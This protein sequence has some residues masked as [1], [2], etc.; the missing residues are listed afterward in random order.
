MACS[1][2][3]VEPAPGATFCSQ[4]GTR[5]DFKCPQCSSVVQKDDRFC[6]QCGHHLQSG[7]IESSKGLICRLA[8]MMFWNCMRLV[9]M[10]EAMI[11]S[12]LFSNSLMAQNPSI[13]GSGSVFEIK[14]PVKF[15]ARR[16]EVSDHS[17]SKDVA[18]RK[19]RVLVAEDNIVNQKIVK[20]YFERLNHDCHIVPPK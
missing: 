3:G 4:C 20:K 2:C 7:E 8:I 14:L 16:I 15:K 17:I 10:V 12:V 11:R 1:A 9:C 18:S 5:L 19:L 13:V 6:S